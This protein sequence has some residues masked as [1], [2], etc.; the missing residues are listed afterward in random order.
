MPLIDRTVTTVRLRLFIKSAQ[1]GDSLHYDIFF[2][3]FFITTCTSV[4]YNKALEVT[5]HDAQNFQ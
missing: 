4:S 3:T 5:A 2:A 1:I